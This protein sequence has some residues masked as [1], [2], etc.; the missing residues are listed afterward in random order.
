MYAR[1][2]AD[3][4]LNFGVS[5]KLWKGSLVMVDKETDSLWSHLLGQGIEGPMKGQVLE[6]IPSVMTDWKSWKELYP[7]TTFVIMKRSSGQYTRDFAT[8][9]KGLVIG[10]TLKDQSR[11]W[12]F[13]DLKVQPMVND[14]LGAKALLI[15]YQRNSETALI[16][17][18]LVEQKEL[19]F[20]HRDRH[21]MGH[22]YRNCNNRTLE[23]ETII[24]ATCS[25]FGGCRI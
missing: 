2:V 17:D 19:T 10:L 11:V 7:K 14:R 8:K 13:A 24:A 21:A 22:D 4:T 15:T 5:G 25:R 18:R 1:D 3:Q 6:T 20:E 23:R 12:K 16:F 9:T